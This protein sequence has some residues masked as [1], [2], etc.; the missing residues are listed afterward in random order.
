M[1][2]MLQASLLL[3]ACATLAAPAEEA[4]LLR[5]PSICGEQIAFVYA[6]DIW[7]VAAGGGEARRLT[8]HPGRELFPVL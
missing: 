4:R 5:F 1:K 8:S 2:P 7:T 3:L 6:G